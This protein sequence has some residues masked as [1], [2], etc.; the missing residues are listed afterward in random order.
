MTVETARP[1]SSA[2][3]GGTQGDEVCCGNA[4]GYDQRGRGR[5]EGAADEGGFAA[6]TLHE[7]GGRQ[8]ARCDAEYG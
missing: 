1:A 5:H 4:P 7:Q 6:D 3:T 8:R 2:G